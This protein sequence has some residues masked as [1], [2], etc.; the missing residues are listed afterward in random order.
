MS[1]VETKTEEQPKIVSGFQVALLENG[2]IVLNLL[3]PNVVGS[4]GLCKFIESQF[5]KQLEVGTE[6]K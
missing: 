2:Q 4:L 3:H 5:I 6:A 1:E